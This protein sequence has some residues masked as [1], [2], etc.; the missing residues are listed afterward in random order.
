MVSDTANT[1]RKKQ[2]PDLPGC[3]M[4]TEE[5]QNMFPEWKFS[6]LISGICGLYRT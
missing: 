1:T 4:L 6:K 3:E 2:L 5:N